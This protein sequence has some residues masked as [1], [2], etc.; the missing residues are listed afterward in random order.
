M[1]RGALVH[2]WP[3]L[4]QWF[5]LGH[6]PDPGWAA[7]LLCRGQGAGRRARQDRLSL[8]PCL[9][10]LRPPSQFQKYSP[11]PNLQTQWLENQVAQ[12]CEPLDLVWDLAGPSEPTSERWGGPYPPPG[13]GGDRLPAE[14]SVACPG[15][16]SSVI[17]GNCSLS[18]SL[19]RAGCVQTT[20]PKPSGQLLSPSSPLGVHPAGMWG[21][22]P[23]VSFLPSPSRHKVLLLLPY[24][25]PPLLSALPRPDSGL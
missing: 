3:L 8:L 19:G 4:G 21:C 16:P 11:S 7:P 24:K 14:G 13:R 2:S 6:W 9:Q 10:S 25:C 5:G 18:F 23:A 22:A 12:D 15:A 17:R 1:T 20:I